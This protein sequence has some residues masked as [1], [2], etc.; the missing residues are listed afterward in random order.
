MN[1]DSYKRN[2]EWMELNTDV[3]AA[4]AGAEPLAPGTHP[5]NVRL[6]LLEHTTLPAKWLGRLFSVGGIRWQD[7]KLQLHAFPA[8]DPE[9]DPIFYQASVQGAPRVKVLFEDDFCLVLLKPVGMAVHAAKP[10]Q[11]GTLDIAAAGHA[12]QAKD[13]LL[14]RHIHRLDEDTSGPVLYSK[15][16][17]AQQKLDE[18]MREKR[19]DRRYLAVV[20]GRPLHKTGTIDEPIG[21]DRHHSSKRIVI[22]GGEKAVTHYEMLE[23]WGSASLLRLQLET[24][25]T[26]QIRVHM[27]F[28]GHPLLGDLLYGGD[29]S[30][31][32]HQA[33]HGETLTFPH[34][35][36]G[37]EVQVT[38]PT[39]SWFTQLK[40]KLTAPS[41]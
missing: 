1:K 29:T 35:W 22:P 40:E 34:P 24:G 28:N 37:E 7:G 23:R 33:L 20:Q 30:L 14:L 4:D 18:A 13:P 17:I 39:P 26:H 3:I 16:E 32:Q 25:R 21:K 36:T 2:G 11:P 19:I 15:N 8:L 5:H 31:I 9:K 38:A 10:G 41:N 6:W 12:L 27:G